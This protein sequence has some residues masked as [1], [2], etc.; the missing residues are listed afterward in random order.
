VHDDRGGEQ[1]EAA[2]VEH[3][4]LIAMGAY[5]HSRA[6]EF[7]LGGLTRYMLKNTTLPL[8]MMH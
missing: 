3:V 2:I 6:R 1:E 8:L 7:L 4:S 5:G